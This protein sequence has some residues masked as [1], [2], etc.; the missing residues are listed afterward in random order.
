MNR[1]GA[2]NAA[3]YRSDPRYL[4]SKLGIEGAGRWP[5]NY[6]GVRM[7][8]LKLFPEGKQALFGNLRHPNSCKVFV[9]W[10]DETASGLSE[11]NVNPGEI[12]VC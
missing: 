9:Q 10:A 11:I 2:L 6:G 5:L 1:I 12:S 7:S 8:S 3:D 4:V